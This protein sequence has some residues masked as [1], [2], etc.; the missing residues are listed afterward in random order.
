MRTLV[1]LF[2][3]L[4]TPDYVQ[5]VQCLIFL[6]EPQP[7]ADILQKLSKGNS[8]ESLMANQIA[9]DMY[10]SASQ[11]F[12]ARVLSA[13][14]GATKVATP[15]PEKEAAEKAEGAE[16]KEE[17][18]A[19]PEE[20]TKPKDDSKQGRIDK[21]AFILSDK[22]PIYLNLQFLIPNDH[23]DPLILKQTKDAVLVSVCHTAKV[24]ANGLMHNGTTHDQFLRDNLDWLSR[25][26][27]WAKL[28]ATATLEVIHR[29]H[30]KE[31]LS[32]MQSYLPKD[33]AGTSSGY[34]EGGG[35]YALGLIHANHGGEITE[36]LLGQVKET[37]NEMI[38]HAGCLGL[39]L[40]STGTHRADVYEQLKFFLYQDDAVTGEAAGLAISLTELA[41]KSAQS[42]DD[43]VAYAQVR[44]YQTYR[45]F[46]V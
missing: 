1:R 30:K 29:G 16:A 39:G 15:A 27:N 46:S 36:Y 5:M 20:K 45:K 23:T 44:N 3:S 19:K 40:A 11:Q 25:A 4:A 41:S 34:A 7:V 21:L 18:E 6:E 35:L 8:Q 24:I 28:S 38:K 42:I 14:P 37:T 9:F 33:A 10:E 32:L 43:M 22:K 2:K 13:I 26:T 31:S 17:A 12:L